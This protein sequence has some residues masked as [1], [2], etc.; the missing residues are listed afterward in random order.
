MFTKNR[1]KFKFNLDQIR[2][3]QKYYR[4]RNNMRGANPGNV[5]EFSHVHY[6][7]NHRYNHPSQKPEAL[8]ERIILASS[9]QDDIILDP[10][11]G[12]GTSLKVAKLLNRRAIG[13]EINQEYIE[14][15]QTRL[16]DSNTSLDSIDLRLTRIPQAVKDS[17]YF[18]LHQE[19][20]LKNK[21]EI[22]KKLKKDC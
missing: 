10:F 14:L 4:K 21:A 1:K 20:F 16:N 22:I 11:A 12:S 3:P 7:S 15:I 8:F 5:W 6:S 18:A 2:I 13:I 17:E 9:N 19:W